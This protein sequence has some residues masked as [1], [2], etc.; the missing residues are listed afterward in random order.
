MKK[1]SIFSSTLKNL[2]SLYEAIQNE[3]IMKNN[4]VCAC[5]QLW[6]IIWR[7]ILLKFYFYSNDGGL[8]WHFEPN[9]CGSLLKRQ[10]PP[11]FSIMMNLDHQQT[12]KFQ[13]FRFSFLLNNNSFARQLV[14][15][16]LSES[17]P[18]LF[19][20]PSWC[21]ESRSRLFCG[22][23]RCRSTIIKAFT[24]TSSCWLNSYLQTANYWNIHFFLI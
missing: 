5:E 15:L 9:L 11:S 24:P 19:F 4:R 3:V 10:K 14:H 18:L 6:L 2:D 13:K 21:I 16:F 17:K 12:L 20:Q 1:T 7:A 22:W 23:P 8:Y